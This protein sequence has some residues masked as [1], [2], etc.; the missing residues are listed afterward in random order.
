MH[1]H[2][3]SKQAEALLP[4]NQELLTAL[5]EL[6][7]YPVLSSV[8]QLGWRQ[9]PFQNLLKASGSC[10]IYVPM[11]GGHYLP[12]SMLVH[13]SS[14]LRTCGLSGHVGMEPWV[15]GL[16]LFLSKL[17]SLRPLLDRQT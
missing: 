16:G 3:A 13:K 6:G 7:T 11:G 1:F 9:G 17:V 8:L 12:L 4:Q 5:S 14:L 2:G 15:I 10:D